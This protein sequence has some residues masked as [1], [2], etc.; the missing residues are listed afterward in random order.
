VFARGAL[1]WTWVKVHFGLGI[2]GYLEWRRVVSF[3]SSYAGAPGTI[4]SVGIRAR[5]ILD[6]IP[7]RWGRPLASLLRAPLLRG[8]YRETGR[9]GCSI[10]KGC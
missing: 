10:E 9:K 5:R 3:V 7:L 2:A 6:A 1:R 8:R 4:P